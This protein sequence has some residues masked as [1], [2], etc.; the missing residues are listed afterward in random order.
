MP[1]FPS[2]KHL[3][4]RLK[5]TNFDILVI[6][7]GATGSGAFVEAASRGLKV[8]LIEKNDFS[9]G[10]SSR[11]TK[12]IHGG[13]RYL[14]NAFKRLDRHEYEL[15]RD[16]LRERA[17]FLKNAP[18][19]TNP[20]PILTPVYGWFDAFYYLIGLKV[21]DLLSGDATLGPSEF[22]SRRQMIKRY[23]LVK[24][25]GLKGAVSFYDGQFDDARMNITLILSGIRES[26]VA[27]NYLR[28]DSLIIEQ[29]R[30]LGAMGH[31]L[32]SGENFPITARTVINATG[33]F[34]DHIRHMERPEVDAL[35]VA[36]QGTHILLP[37]KFSPSGAG[38]IIPDT[39]D[40]RV[41][42][43]LPWQGKT[44][45]GTT[46]NVANISDTPKAS[47]EE[48]DYI[49]ENVAGLVDVKPK[50]SDV[51]ATWSGLRPLA[52]PSKDMKSAC[53]SRDHL[54]E[55]S[56]G[57][58]IT[59]VGG[60]WTTYRKMGEDVINTAITVG[61]LTPARGSITKDLRLV[62]ARFFKENLAE[63]L[64]R[65]KKLAPDIAAHLAKSYGDR[66]E[67]I[68][69]LG[70]PA[71]SQRLL[72]G[73]PFIE[74]EVLYATRYEYALSAFDIIARRMRLA[75]LDYHA[76]KKVLPKVVSLMSQELAWPQSRKNEELAR[77][78]ALLETMFTA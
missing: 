49:L 2:R 73:Y 17:R 39:E 19:L 62:G 76:A 44:L 46:D 23:P 72:E 30:V 25:K 27:L 28:A 65:Q 11:S 63:E 16:A 35:M 71:L 77:A 51:L 7:G 59:I 41:V 75:F 40:G 42:F 38:L 47:G 9:A 22:I 69:A 5:E 56:P 21:Y 12:L 15:V 60:K 50:R 57:H 13:V 68:L 70:T 33:C 37:A 10:T 6:G 14:E 53:I 20:L 78:L 45:A 58:L 43:I 66:V 48:V 29:G 54:I 18:H 61:E 8:A 64:I 32:E 74:A 4:S 24:Q 31:D 3:I 52:R 36:S 34:A 26:G 55:V 1:S 67:T